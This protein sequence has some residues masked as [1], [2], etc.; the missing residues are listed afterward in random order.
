MHKI[1]I[2][3]AFLIVQIGF[4]Q[5][6]SETL[7]NEDFYYLQKSKRLEIG[8]DKE[9]QLSI[10]NHILDKGKFNT[11][12][13]LFYANDYIYFDSFTEVKDIKAFTYNPTTSETLEVDHFETKDEIRGGVFY[14]DNQSIHFVYPGVTKGAETNLQYSEKISEPHFSNTFMFGSGVPIQEAIYTVEVDNKVTLGIKTFNLENFDISYSKEEGKKT[15]KHI[16]KAKNIHAFN[17]TANSQSIFKYVPHVVIYIKNYKIKRKEVSIFNSLDDLYAWNASLNAQ[18]DRSGLEEVH[19]IA[20][21]ITAGLTTQHQKAQA[22]F[23]WVQQNINYVAFEYGYGG[24]IA[25]GAAS[26]CNKRYGDCKD[27][28]NLLYEMLIHVGIDAHHTWIGSRKKPYT[29]EQIPTG[30]IYDHMIT[31]VFIDGETIFLDATDNYVP[32]GMPSAFIQGKEGMV[33]MTETTYKVL[34]VPVQKPF[35]NTT[36]VTN[37]IEIINDELVAKSTRKMTGYDMVD[38]IYDAQFKKDEKTNEVYLSTKYEI[39]NNKTSFSNI[40]LGNFKPEN[41]SYK[42]AYDIAINNYTKKIGSKLIFNPHLEK[43][44]SKDVLQLE[45]EKYGKDINHKFKRSFY[46]RF[47]IP[48]GYNVSFLPKNI[49]EERDDYGFSFTYSVN[50]NTITVNQEIYM[51]TIAI[52]NDQLE[53]YN[54]F[55]KKIIKAYKK[56]VVLEKINE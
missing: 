49:K 21:S 3:L 13:K 9:H 2:I 48:D 26:V 29:H 28:S 16:W 52:D 18:V 41:G 4:A 51:N 38:F 45:A 15:T 11:G 56:S 55:I 8:L 43:P 1:R 46:S 40:Q 44:W 10:E 25:R 39:G 32:Y 27:M 50:E 34:S 53:A 30:K 7:K 47:M 12:K 17:E 33:G 31:T 42:I 24:L 36:K 23:E 37:E 5:E 54:S 14:S 6:A 22:I 19:Q 35:K 20:E